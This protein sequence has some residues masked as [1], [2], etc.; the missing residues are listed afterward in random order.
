MK[1]DLYHNMTNLIILVIFMSIARI[2]SLENFIVKELIEQPLEVK[3]VKNLKTKI[4][5]VAISFFAKLPFVNVNFKFA[6]NNIFL[7]SIFSISNVIGY[8]ALGSK[9]S[10][11]LIEEHFEFNESKT[12]NIFHDRTSKIIKGAIIAKSIF[13]GL[14]SRSL[15]AYIAY[16]YNNNN[17]FYPLVIFLCDSSFTIYSLKLS[18]EKLFRKKGNG[19]EK[20]IKLIKKDIVTSVEDKKSQVTSLSKE[21]Q[22]TFFK[23][24]Q[25][26]KNSEGGTEKTK[27]Y[28]EKVTYVKNINE[29]DTKIKKCFKLALYIPGLQLTISRVL[30]YAIS[31]FFGAKLFFK[32]NIIPFIISFLVTSSNAYLNGIWIMSSTK[33]VLMSL[34]DFFNSSYKLSI[35][36]RLR[37]TLTFS[38]KALAFLIS[39]FS[40]APFA[41]VMQDS[42]KG[43][44]SIYIQITL[45]IAIALLVSKAM[46]SIIDEIVKFIV[47]R[48][49]SFEEKN[50]LLLNNEMQRLINVL[51]KSTFLEFAKF[52]NIISETQLKAILD[53]YKVNSQ[54]LKEYIEKM[55]PKEEERSLIEAV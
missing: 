49:G 39:I 47:L 33:S 10:L 45:S 11:H 48:K 12:S 9:S 51:E 16:K 52:L 28:L 7:G 32:D 41:Q 36:E 25:E 27:K 18:F 26:I 35:S 23:E 24:L 50:I 53:K 30:Y 31:C 44:F 2:D 21:G 1:S 4:A 22:T 38:L 15:N 29:E 42:M 14:S 5:A 40:G 46:F 6:Q 43:S 37:P 13:F 17:L 20:K 8:W 19:I 3:K 34:K 55:S 54:M